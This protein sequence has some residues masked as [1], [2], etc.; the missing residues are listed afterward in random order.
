[1]TSFYLDSYGNILFAGYGIKVPYG[2]ASTI[3]NGY[4]ALLDKRGMPFW[5]FRV[6]DEQKTGTADNTFCSFIRH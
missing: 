1:M 3:Q 2:D 5:V 6:K 4:L